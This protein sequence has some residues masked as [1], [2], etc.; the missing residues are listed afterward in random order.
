[1]IKIELSED[2]LIYLWDTMCYKSNWYRCE[3][4]LEEDLDKKERLLRVY[5]EAEEI[6]ER[7][8]KYMPKEDWPYEYRETEEV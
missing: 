2:D 3:A 6:I 1:M 7:L 4:D 8:F 5:E